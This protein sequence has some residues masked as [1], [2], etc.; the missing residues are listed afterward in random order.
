[1]VDWTCVEISE[2]FLVEKKYK[3]LTLKKHEVE[4]AFSKGFLSKREYRPHHVNIDIWQDVN[5]YLGNP[6]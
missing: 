5:V 3:N 6:Y 4:I 2:M 1:M